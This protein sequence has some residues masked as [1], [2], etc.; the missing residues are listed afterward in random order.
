MDKY[1]CYFDA[2]TNKRKKKSGCSF[3]VIK[4]DETIYKKSW[5]MKINDNNKAER[6]ALFQ[7]LIHIQK[8]IERKSEINIYGDACS[9]IEQII[10]HNRKID[11]TKFLFHE[12]LNKHKIDLIYI[13][14]EMNYMADELAYEAQLGIYTDEKNNFELI[15]FNESIRGYEK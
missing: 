10:A 4:N 9:I 3:I 14:R 12:L 5:K 7:L 1:E 11:K 8:N 2:S 15:E 13:D 6:E